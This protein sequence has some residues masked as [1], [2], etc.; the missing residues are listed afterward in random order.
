MELNALQCFIATAKYLN[1]TKAA[2]ELY[3]SQPT[4]SYHISNL[5]QELG[6]VLFDRSKKQIV[7]TEA[8]RILHAEAEAAFKHLT[9]AKDKISN[10]QSDKD[11][12]RF[13]FL[14]LLITPCYYRFVDPFL[15]E[16]P[17]VQARLERRGTAII[18]GLAENSQYD[19]VFTRGLARF[20]KDTP[21]DLAFM[22][23]IKDAVSIIVPDKEP[24]STMDSISD[25]SIL[26]DTQLLT[27]DPIISG[28]MFSGPLNVLLLEHG[29]NP[30]RTARTVANIDDLLTQIIA[31]QGFGI[32]PT[33]SSIELAYKG[34]R[35]IQLSGNDHGLADVVVAWNPDHMNRKNRTYLDYLTKIA[36]GKIEYSRS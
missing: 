1:F 33:Y 11:T 27:I 15:K 18:K 5:E 30:D 12:L 9:I 20:D 7:L 34:I 28:N 22:T 19:F 13:G 17:S 8:G 10:L 21:K 36:G 32:L 35:L 6:T 16:Y 14:E 31:G 29:F 24:F 2:N 3:I 25:L 4:L 23:L 26:N